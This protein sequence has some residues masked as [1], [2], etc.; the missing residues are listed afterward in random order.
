MN[1]L[2]RYVGVDLLDLIADS[3]F[4]NLEV[5]DHPVTSKWMVQIWV[6]VT[7]VVPIVDHD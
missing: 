3:S 7:N 5:I 2:G 6:I 4:E 1:D